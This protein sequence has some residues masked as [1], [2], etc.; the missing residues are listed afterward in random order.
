M[1]PTGAGSAPS[2]CP[3]PGAPSESPRE[4][5]EGEQGK[6]REFGLGTALEM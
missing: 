3:R 1:G 6:E 5:G 4:A 2:S